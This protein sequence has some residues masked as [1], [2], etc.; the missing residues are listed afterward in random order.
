MIKAM[1]FFLST[2]LYHAVTPPTTRG[3][4]HKNKIYHSAVQ[5]GNAKVKTIEGGGWLSFRHQDLRS[6]SSTVIYDYFLGI[7]GGPTALLRWQM[8][9]GLYHYLEYDF[10]VS[11]PISRYG[12]IGT[13]PLS[14][15]EHLYQNRADRSVFNRLYTK[16]EETYG[17]GVGLSPVAEA[18]KGSLTD[19]V[20]QQIYVDFWCRGEKQVEVY[21]TEPH[22]KNRLT[23]SDFLPQLVLKVDNIDR[24]RNLETSQSLALRWKTAGE[25]TFDW[26]GPFYVTATGDERFF[27]TDKGRVYTPP[28]DAKPGALLKELWKGAPVDVLIHDADHKTW[29]A[30]TKDQYFEVADPIKPKPH[31]LTIRRS[32]FAEP[33]LDTAAKC[34]RVIRGLP[35]PK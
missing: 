23:R 12:A 1:L 8:S 28:K 20:K 5:F 6:S 33:A 24:T 10:V 13:V 27:V 34:G 7:Y 32:W 26:T 31:T 14:A 22:K 3:V 11:Q 19:S 16:H 15:L 9:N 4:I 35:E 2:I 18:F 25:W 21:V 17:G 30:F 29:Y